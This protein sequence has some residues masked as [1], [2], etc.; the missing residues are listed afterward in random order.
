MFL[1]LFTKLSTGFQRIFPP[2]LSLSR[3]ILIRT[4]LYPL[5]HS[6]AQSYPQVVTIA[7]YA[8]YHVKK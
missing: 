2:Y 5:I 4:V 8:G 6:F 1:E 7:D 3:L